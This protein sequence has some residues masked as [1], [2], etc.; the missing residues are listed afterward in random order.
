[1]YA[2]RSLLT[3]NKIKET[4]S[5]H[6]KYWNYISCQELGEGNNTLQERKVFYLQK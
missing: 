5:K 6:L 2:C 3:S 4:C 1:M